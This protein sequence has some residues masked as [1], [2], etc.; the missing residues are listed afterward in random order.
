MI[1]RSAQLAA[2]TTL[3]SVTI[4][5]GKATIFD[6][7]SGGAGVNHAYKLNVLSLSDGCSIVDAKGNAVDLNNLALADGSTTLTLYFNGF[8]KSDKLVF[9]VDV[10]DTNPSSLFAEAA[11]F[12]TNTAEDGTV[13]QGATI[14]ATF[15]VGSQLKASVIDLVLTEYDDNT[16][17]LSG[18]DASQWVIAGSGDVWTA[19][20]SAP[21]AGITGGTAFASWTEPDNSAYLN[22]LQMSYFPG[23]A[24]T[25]HV[26]SDQ[27]ATTDD[28]PVAN[29]TPLSLT[30][31]DANQN[32]ISYSVRFIDLG[33]RPGTVPDGASA[34]LCLAL[35]LVPLVWLKQ[36]RAVRQ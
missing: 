29:G 8:T 7:A 32:P 27:L 6:T 14:G 35:G 9:T 21:L 20:R 16:L 4:D 30:F 24:M 17:G 19:T 3:K 36:R 1:S 23:A 13:V 26:T 22:A 18:A 12:C 34:A 28:S 25:L 33:D 15:S 11:E 10:D 2:G 31:Y 5:L